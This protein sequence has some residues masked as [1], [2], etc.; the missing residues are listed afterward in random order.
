MPALP[1]DQLQI[2]HKDP[3]TG[4]PRTSP[5]LVSRCLEAI[6][7]DIISLAISEA[8]SKFLSYLLQ[9]WPEGHSW[10]PARS[11][12]AQCRSFLPSS[13]LN[14]SSSFHVTTPIP[15]S[16]PK[17]LISNQSNGSSDSAQAGLEVDLAPSQVWGFD[18][19][20]VV[21]CQTGHTLV[22]MLISEVEPSFILPGI[23]STWTETPAG[24]MRMKTKEAVNLLIP[25]CRE[26]LKLQR[27]AR[28]LK[29]EIVTGTGVPV[30]TWFPK[31]MSLLE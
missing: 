21:G 6:Q 3:K 2:T 24:P 1:L 28:L 5:A 22:G 13:S 29:K 31:H 7:P 8:K 20:G 19:L 23:R 30:L 10:D 4:K 12:Q 26:R 14:L 9:E 11:F 27:G 18:P 15:P 25:S 17:H 16:H